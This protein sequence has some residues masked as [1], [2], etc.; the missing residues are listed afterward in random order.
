MWTAIW[1]LKQDKN[2]DNGEWKQSLFYKPYS[3]VALHITDTRGRLRFYLY[4]LK[5]EQVEKEGKKKQWNK[6]QT[7]ERKKKREK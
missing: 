4:L 7:K 6:I 3:R 5:A 2:E 1:A